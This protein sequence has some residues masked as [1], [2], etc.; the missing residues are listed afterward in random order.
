ML[1]ANTSLFKKMPPGLLPLKQMKL[2]YCSCE[3]SG[4]PK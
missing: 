2:L 1:N 3:S 4:M